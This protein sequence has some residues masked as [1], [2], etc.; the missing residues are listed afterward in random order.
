MVVGVWVPKR[1]D[2]SLHALSQY[3]AL[4][5]PPE[6]P[7]IER[8]YKGSDSEDG[9]LSPPGGRQAG[10][11]VRRPPSRRLVRH[12][13]RAR[14]EAVRALGVFLREIEEEEGGRAQMKMLQAK[15]GMIS[16][17]TCSASDS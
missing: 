11:R 14:G 2:V 12:V 3:T 5:I 6:N 9:A 8:L 16:R 15:G 10:R 7:W 1:W 17:Q 4:Q 13:L